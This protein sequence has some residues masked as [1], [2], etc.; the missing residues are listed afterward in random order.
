MPRVRVVA[1]PA[2]HHVL[3]LGGMEGGEVVGY[4]PRAR[5]TPGPFPYRRPPRGGSGQASAAQQWTDDLAKNLAERSVEQL[6]SERAR[7]RREIAERREQRDAIAELLPKLAEQNR[8]TAE[9][10]V[11]WGSSESPDDRARA[12]RAAARLAARGTYVER[13]PHLAWLIRHWRW[14]AGLF[15]VAFVVSYWQIVLPVAVL[16]LA[17]AVPIGRR[18][19]RHQLHAELAARADQALLDWYQTNDPT[20]PTEGS[21]HE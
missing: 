13:R 17:V 2:P 5:H 15:A 19:H 20:P 1:W 18:R 12:D 3:A 7:L 21:D 14:F 8:R 10:F 9:Q 4:R 16:V 6:E 11:D